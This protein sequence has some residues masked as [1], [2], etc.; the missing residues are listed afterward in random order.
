MSR[1]GAE[2]RH[3]LPCKA[4]VKL[5]ALAGAVALVVL[6]FWPW[7][8]LP[9]QRNYSADYGWTRSV[10]FNL[11]RVL[12]TY[13]EAHGQYPEALSELGEPGSDE[14]AFTGRPYLYAAACDN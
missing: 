8:R 7:P 12:D 13:Y 5:V 14:D 1:A 4:V 2:E 3:G 10:F 6:V 11:T 9:W